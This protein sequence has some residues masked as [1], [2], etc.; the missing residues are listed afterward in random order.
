MAPRVKEVRTVTAGLGK[1]V[2]LKGG[3]AEIS[4]SQADVPVLGRG[5]EK[6][7]RKPSLALL[8]EMDSAHLYRE[9]Q[10]LPRSVMGR[11]GLSPSEVI[12]HR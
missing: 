3:E 8:F 12:C 5:R 4:V 6:K 9:G 2:V 1:A 11:P 7:T 10:L